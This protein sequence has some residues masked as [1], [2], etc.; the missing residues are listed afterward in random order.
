MQHIMTLNKLHLVQGR[1]IPRGRDLRQLGQALGNEANPH[2]APR[3]LLQLYA[4]G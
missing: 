2:L 3:S 1:N 4:Q